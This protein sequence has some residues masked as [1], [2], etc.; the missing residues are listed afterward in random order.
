[1][2]APEIV[3]IF[4]ANPIDL[5]GRVS[6]L[7]G[8][9][10]AGGWEI[11]PTSSRN[12]LLANLGRDAITRPKTQSV[13]LI[14]LRSE[15]GDLEQ[16]GF[17]IIETI[18]RHEFLWKVSRPIIWVDERLRR[19]FCSQGEGSAPRRSSTTTG[20]TAKMGSRSS[21]FWSGPPNARAGRMAAGCFAYV[22]RPRDRSMP[23]CA[24][25]TSASNDGLA[26]GLMTSITSSCG[27]W[28]TR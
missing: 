19:I 4:D 11:R 2:S 13:A 20:S 17:R 14:D 7:R 9:G 18:R 27:D 25:V 24:C 1:M 3:Y 22:Q 8:A 12:E 5:R 26:F 6:Q 23:S 15:S 10:V 16:V 28:P 21:R